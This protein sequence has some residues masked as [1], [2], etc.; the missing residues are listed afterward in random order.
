MSFTAE[1]G[2][3]R[4]RK[5]AEAVVRHAVK[6]PLLHRGAADA[7][8]KGNRGFIP[9][10]HIPFQPSATTLCGDVGNVLEQRLP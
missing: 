4:L 7:V 5:N 10:E 8:V 3:S 1:L 9:V 6:N 2:P